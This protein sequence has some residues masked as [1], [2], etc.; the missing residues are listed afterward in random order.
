MNSCDKCVILKNE[1]DQKKLEAEENIRLGNYEIERL[2]EI[3][4]KIQNSEVELIRLVNLKNATKLDYLISLNP[5][6]FEKVI[7]DLYTQLGYKVKQTPKTNDKGKDLV[8]HKGGKKFIV[9]CKR[10]NHKNLVG[11]PEIQKF[12]AVCVEENVEFGFFITTS[13]FTLGAK[14]YP[15]D[16][17]NKIQLV[18]GI[19][20]IKLMEMAYISKNESD[21]YEIVCRDCGDIVQFEFD[22]VIQKLCKS[23]HTVNSNIN[24]I[25]KGIF[26]SA[27]YV[28][29]DPKC[30]ICGGNMK[31]RISKNKKFSPFWGCS[32]YPNC[33]G[34]LSLKEVASISLIDLY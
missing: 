18:N 28:F 1:I 16:I 24:D 7:G 31:K 32:K 17:G 27:N 29:L 11:R 23:N 5:F 15:H 14:T 13:D 4:L 10:Y 12:Y 34:L 20:L 9:E 3:K 25:K 19:A 33:K 6:V 8:M 26:H 21:K 22:V 30:P 2:N